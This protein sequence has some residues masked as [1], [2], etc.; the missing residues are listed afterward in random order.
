[1]SRTAHPPDG[2]ADVVGDQQGAVQAAAQIPRI[3]V[4]R[5]AWVS[6]MPGK[7]TGRRYRPRIGARLD[8]LSGGTYVRLTPSRLTIGNLQRADHG[9]HVVGG[10]GL[11]VLIRDLGVRRPRP[12]LCP[13]AGFSVHR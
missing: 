7:F 10:D 8:H 3:M 5:A 1:M 4:P 12:I 11:A 6:R 9:E 2:I 13:R